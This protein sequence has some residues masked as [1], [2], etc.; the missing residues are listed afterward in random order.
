MKEKERVLIAGAMIRVKS[1]IAHDW[2]RGALVNASFKITLRPLRRKRGS[3][4]E[5]SI[6]RIGYLRSKIWDTEEMK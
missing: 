2:P 3:I 1:P 4:C 6:H 5:I